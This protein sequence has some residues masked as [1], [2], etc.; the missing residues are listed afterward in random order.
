MMKINK[1]DIDLTN[2]FTSKQL[3]VIDQELNDPDWTL[4]I[5]YGAVR[6]GKTYVDNFIFLFELQHAARIAQSKGVAH[7]QYILAGNSSKTIDTNILV[8]LYNTFGI[9]FKF[10]QHNS[11]DV[12]F[13]GL[14]PVRIVQAYTG[15]KRG[16][17]GIRGMTAYG[18]Y[19]NEAS[20]ADEGVFAEIRQRCSADG[21]RVVC[22]TNPDVPTHWLKV[23]YIDKAANSKRIVC[24]H[25]VLDDNIRNLGKTYVESLKETT[26]KGM[27]YDR[28]I[29]GLWVAGEGLVYPDFNENNN[30]INEE[31]F[32]KIKRDYELEYYCGLDWGFEHKGSIVVMAD[33]ENGNTYLVKEFT[34]QHKQID[35]WLDLAHDIQTEYGY[36]IPFYCD[37]ARPEYVEKFR[38][39]N[40]E[41]INAFK[42]IMYGVELIAGKISN[43]HFEAVKNN[44]MDFEKE[45]YQYVWDEKTGK[46]LKQDGMDDT[47]DAMRYAVATKHY[48]QEHEEPG[49]EQTEQLLNN[50]GLIN[51]PFTNEIGGV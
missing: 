21:A 45:I 14:P 38:D 31:E 17:G 26:P 44:L 13:P 37:S 7:P 39:E 23:N 9:Q 48:L 49:I 1:N 51:D 33:D 46:P 35:F 29:L 10:N 34:Y 28:S 36:N 47:M 15:S 2:L 30:I 18:A 3:E 41:A 4:M 25:F 22:D 32:E 43:F 42:S 50:A 5:N 6:A 24:N 11:F 16:I 40:I 19:I 12:K 8:E 27:F 20:L